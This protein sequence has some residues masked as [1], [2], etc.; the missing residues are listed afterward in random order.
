[1]EGEGLLCIDLKRDIAY[2]KNGIK[3]PTDVI[4][5]ADS[6]NPTSGTHQG[7]DREPHLQPRDYL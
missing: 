2:G 4:F 3:R 1:M 6:A 7:H 5:S